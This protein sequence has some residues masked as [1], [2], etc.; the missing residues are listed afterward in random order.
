MPTVQLGSHTVYYDDCGKGHPLLLITGL[1]STRHG[2]WKQVGP[3][4]EKFR[5]I[6]MDNR[7]AGDSALG[8]GPYSIVDMANDAVG[9]IKHLNL[10]PTHVVGI[11]MG[12]FVSIE[13]AI[14]YPEL[15]DKL[16]LTATSAGGKSH[17]N[18]SLSIQLLLVDREKDVEKRVRK[19]YPR[20]TGPGYMKAH[21]EDL[22]RI[23]EIAKARPMSPD[24]YKRQLDAVMKHDAANRLDAIS[25]P[26]LVIH[27]DKDP[28]VPYKN[29]Q[30]LAAHINGAR[31]VTLPGVGHLV[32][33]EAPER[34]NRE[35]VEF[36]SQP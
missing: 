31:L 7:D 5:V 33:V 10:G 8:T 36:L 27:G 32:T 11:S 24:S 14:R 35:V 29:G 28:L 1:A 23:V 2:W 19:V 21:P 25:K 34:F 26:T 13:M 4:S 18:P 6:N 22:E 20:F 15:V 16:V 30:Y 17:V 12:G 3:F 9:L